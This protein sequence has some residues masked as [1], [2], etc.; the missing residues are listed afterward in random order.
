MATIADSKRQKNAASDGLMPMLWALKRCCEQREAGICGELG[1]STGELRCLLAMGRESAH[2]LGE[3]A[4]R[5]QL[6][7]SR[8]SRLVE[9]LAER[10]LIERTAP[11]ADRR[12]SSL[13]L[14]AKGGKFLKRAGKLMD[15]CEAELRE[16]LG[17][18][19]AAQVNQS[20]AE[21][22]AVMEPT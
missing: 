6:S 10:G 2:S 22:L 15:A 11:S 4:E 17:G 14:S 7:L 9:R 12:V 16:Q 1:L 13:A 3:L 20:L 19:R 21:L 5:L 18:R 8:A